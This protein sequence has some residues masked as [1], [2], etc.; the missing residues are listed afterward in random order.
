MEGGQA[1]PFRHHPSK[2]GVVLEVGR[3]R[4][5]WGK[6]KV[7]GCVSSAPSVSLQLVYE[8]FLRFLESPDFQP[9][10]AKRYIDQKF[11]LLVSGGV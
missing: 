1:Q 11:V 3:T 9:S 6:G 4:V 7:G 5:P 2:A 8:F 10:V